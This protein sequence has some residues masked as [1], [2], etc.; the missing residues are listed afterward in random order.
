LRDLCSHVHI[1]TAQYA[2]NSVYLCNFDVRLTSLIVIRL[3][4]RTEEVKV[5]FV[6]TKV[7][8]CYKHTL[9]R[10]GGRPTK[11]GQTISWSALWEDGR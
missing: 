8:C 10:R 4:R 3:V 7:R 11:L 6:Q 1:L 9:D 2:V 5:K